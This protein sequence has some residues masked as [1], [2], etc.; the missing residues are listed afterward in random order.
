MPNQ[1]PLWLKSEKR[2]RL[3]DQ[4]PTS[5]APTMTSNASAFHA[6]SETPAS[7]F[8]FTEDLDYLCNK[9]PF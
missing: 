7:A 5:F 6:L 3:F 2:W 8:V 1:S 4:S 9:R